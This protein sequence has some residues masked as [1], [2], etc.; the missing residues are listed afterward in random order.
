VEK[1]TA[2]RIYEAVHTALQADKLGARIQHDPTV[3]A[4]AQAV[5]AGVAVELDKRDALIREGFD[6]M[7]ES[8]VRMI[9]TPPAPPGAPKA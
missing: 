3:Q 2:E 7:Y 8:L 5:A 4:L 6:S 9:A 1:T